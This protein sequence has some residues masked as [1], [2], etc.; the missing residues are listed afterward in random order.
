[1]ET[2]E[3]GWDRM[4]GVGSDGRGGIGLESLMRREMW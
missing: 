2:G 1:M 4:G 3:M